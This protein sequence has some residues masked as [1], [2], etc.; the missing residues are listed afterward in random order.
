MPLF[1]LD[2]AAFD[3]KPVL[4]CNVAVCDSEAPACDWRHFQPAAGAPS[5]GVELSLRERGTI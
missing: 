4:D 2:I 5:Q 1:D 3:W